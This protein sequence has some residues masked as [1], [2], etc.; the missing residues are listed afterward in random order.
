MRRLGIVLVVLLLAAMG[1]LASTFFPQRLPVS[2][3]P[4]GPLPKADSPPE[5][6]LSLLR[7][8][9]MHAKAAFAYRGG[10][11]SDTREFV[12][13]AALVHHPRGD[14]LI[15]AGFAR[16]VDDHVRSTT[17]WLLRSLSSY[18]K[19]VPAAD[20]LAAAGYPLQ[21]L[22][23]VVITHS[24]W[25]HVSGLADLPGVPVWM[26][27]DERQFVASGASMADLMR[28]FSGLAIREYPWDGGAYLGFERSHDF[29][30]D[31]SIVLAP[32][33]GHTPGSTIVFVNL[34]SGARYAFV[35][36]L[37]WQR[38]GVEIPAERPWGARMVVDHDP[39]VERGSLLR[40]ARVHAVFPSIAVVP[41]HDARAAAELPAFPASRD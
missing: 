9:T 2:N 4:L 33:P 14:I 30:G 25:D 5:M 24:H 36:D 16:A 32:A 10:S 6:T 26:N 12:M 21:R 19:G 39:A 8:G 15:D 40:M 34:P 23:G 31:G 20:Q 29:W 17:P 7:T 22:A 3:E 11:F 37:A 35:G 28:S 38:E 13:T 41:A 27:A 18:T 1:V